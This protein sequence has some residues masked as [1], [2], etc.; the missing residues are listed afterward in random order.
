VAVE[1]L[2]ME[3]GEEVDF[4]IDDE[5][6]LFCVVRHPKQDNRKLPDLKELVA[7]YRPEQDHPL[8]ET[9][10]VLFAEEYIDKETI[11]KA[12]DLYYSIIRDETEDDSNYTHEQKHLL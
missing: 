1:L 4:V 12:A 3:K 2:A 8:H 10:R 11:N 5:K 7:Q 6:D 9:S